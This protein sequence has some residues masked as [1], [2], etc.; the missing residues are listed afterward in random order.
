[1]RRGTQRS[2]ADSWWRGPTLLGLSMSQAVGHCPAG[3]HSSSGLLV[4]WS[5]TVVFVVSVLTGFDVDEVAVLA[6]FGAVLGVGPAAASLR[7][8]HMHP[9]IKRSHW[10]AK[11]P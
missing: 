6:G 10:L 5:A 4:L 3:T 2:R 7:L 1:M 8:L 9:H 11:G